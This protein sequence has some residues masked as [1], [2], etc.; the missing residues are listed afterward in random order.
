M[1]SNLSA[2][3]ETGFNLEKGPK[4][5]PVEARMADQ[6]GD[7]QAATDKAFQQVIADIAA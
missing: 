1:V 5:W 3:T 4:T 2:E 7:E 6:Y